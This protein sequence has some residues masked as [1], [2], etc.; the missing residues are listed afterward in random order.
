MSGGED[1]VLAIR[2][3]TA[4]STSSCAC[5]GQFEVLCLRAVS[6]DRLDKMEQRALT[7]VNPFSIE[8]KRRTKTFLQA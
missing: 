5:V 2:A 7:A 4:A 1:N 8:G 6:R 3:R